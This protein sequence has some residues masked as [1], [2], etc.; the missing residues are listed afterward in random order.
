[1]QFGAHSDIDYYVLGMH[2]HTRLKMCGWTHI[3]L[4]ISDE[5]NIENGHLWW[6][7]IWNRYK[8]KNQYQKTIWKI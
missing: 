2:G 3:K 6:N 7:P 8:D 4:K 1:M 5:A